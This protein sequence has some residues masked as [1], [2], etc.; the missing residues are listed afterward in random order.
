VHF[1]QMIEQVSFG[2][3]QEAGKHRV[4]LGRSEPFQC[5]HVVAFGEQRQMA[6]DAGVDHPQMD[7]I[8]HQ[9]VHLP[10]ARHIGADRRGARLWRIFL[11][12]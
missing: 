10:I 1:N 6:H 8:G 12:P 5:I 9:V 11:E 7:S 2:L 3:H 4:P